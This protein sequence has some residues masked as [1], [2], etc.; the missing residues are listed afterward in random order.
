[1]LKI[2]RDVAACRSKR[3]NLGAGARKKDVSILCALAPPKPSARESIHL[4]CPLDA[5]GRRRRRRRSEDGGVTFRNHIPNHLSSRAPLGVGPACG[6]GSVR[7]R[8]IK[9][10]RRTRRSASA[11]AN[12]TDLIAQASPPAPFVDNLRRR[13]AE[14]FLKMRRPVPAATRNAKLAPLNG[15]DDDDNR[16]AR[17]CRQLLTFAHAHSQITDQAGASARASRPIKPAPPSRLFEDHTHGPRRSSASRPPP[18]PNGHIKRIGR[19]PPTKTD[20]QF[21]MVAQCRA[22]ERDKQTTTGAS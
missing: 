6:I 9:R 19:W 8:P 17:R 12:C 3:I 22:G 14:I 11:Y 10:P 20:D 16:P 5:R 18:P 2:A 15:D 1:M 21:E 4:M 13:R 7:R